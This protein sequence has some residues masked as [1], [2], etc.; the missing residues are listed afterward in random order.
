MSSDRLPHIG[1]RTTTAAQ[2]RFIRLL[3]SDDAPLRQL[4]QRGGVSARELGQWSRGRMFRATIGV[5]LRH[6]P[7]RRRR[8]AELYFLAL[9]NRAITTVC[10]RGELDDDERNGDEG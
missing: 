5:M 2:R 8:E 9:R 6:S 3:G 4:A 10:G 7:L 1:S